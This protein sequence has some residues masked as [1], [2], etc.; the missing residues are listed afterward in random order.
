M[1]IEEAIQHCEEVAAG[2]TEQGKCP[3]CAADHR[4]L[5]EWLRELVALRSQRKT[6][7]TLDR[8]QWW[9][10]PFCSG[11][12]DDGGDENHI[13]KHRYCY[14]CGKPLTELAWAELGRKI[15]SDIYARNDTP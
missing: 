3:E 15:G 8:N 11:K 13:P 6:H 5:A 1:T 2:K 7:A 12:E 10:C 9:G 14:V 4:Q